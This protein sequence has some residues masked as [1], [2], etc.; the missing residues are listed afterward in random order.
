MLEF[1]STGVWQ[2]M[3][4]RALVNNMKGLGFDGYKVNEGALF[5]NAFNSQKNRN[6]SNVDNT[7]I[8]N[9]ANI[10]SPLAH[11]NPKLAGVGAGSVLSADLMADELDL[12]Y[13]GQEPSAWDSLMKDIGNVNQQQAQGVADM[14]ANVIGGTASVASMLA[15][16]PAVVGEVIS[17]AGLKTLGAVSPYIKGFGLGLLLDA[18]ELGN[19]SMYSDEEFIKILEEKQ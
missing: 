16:D 18:S 19:G 6:I 8:F 15:T 17:T 12:E 11:F 9:P 14:S 4:D 3:E 10:R 5:E 1:A 13:K 2:A 7:A